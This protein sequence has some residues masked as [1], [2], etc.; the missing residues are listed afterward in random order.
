[1]PP[2]SITLVI[3]GQTIMHSLDTMHVES[4]IHWH[5][6]NSA[7]TCRAVSKHIDITF[8]LRVPC[9]NLIVLVTCSCIRNNACK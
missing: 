8:A 2:V 3:T 4:F 7:C 9:E 6:N 5:L 1:M